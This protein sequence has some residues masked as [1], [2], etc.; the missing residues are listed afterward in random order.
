[1]RCMKPAKAEW[2]LDLLAREQGRGPAGKQAEQEQRRTQRPTRPHHRQPPQDTDLSKLALLDERFWTGLQAQKVQ[3]EALKRENERLISEVARLQGA[4]AELVSANA[5]MK[6]ALGQP[7]ANGLDLQ[8]DPAIGSGGQPYRAH[9]DECKTELLVGLNWYHKPGSDEDLCR[10]HWKERV[11]R[12]QNPAVPSFV[13]VC[14]PA[15]L[16]RDCRGYVDV[17]AALDWCEVRLQELEAQMT[18]LSE[19]Q[20]DECVQLQNSLQEAVSQA[21][22]PACGRRAALAAFQRHQALAER[23]KALLP[24]PPGAM[25]ALCKA[26]GG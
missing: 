17:D 16:G 22:R 2:Q 23:A 8:E 25:T 26:G 3:A 6:Q 19:A 20:Q 24:R 10:T 18:D 7:K 21:L 15:A 9:C 1:M 11:R 5:E 12:L 13:L 14:E 4:T